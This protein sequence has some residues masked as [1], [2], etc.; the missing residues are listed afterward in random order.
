MTCKT[1]NGRLF[2][3]L[4]ILESAIP[5]LT[6]MKRHGHWQT[7]FNFEDLGIHGGIF[8]DPENYLKGVTAEIN[9]R[10]ARMIIPK[11]YR[12]VKLKVKDIDGGKVVR[13]VSSN[14]ECLSQ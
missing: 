7:E 11:I 8:V 1:L 9:I 12:P 3:D 14:L 5:I 4:K 10:N 2:D 13:M 6:R